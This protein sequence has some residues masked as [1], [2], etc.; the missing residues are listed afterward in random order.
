MREKREAPTITRKILPV[1]EALLGMYVTK[2]LSAALGRGVRTSIV[3]GVS[4][5]GFR[6]ATDLYPFRRWGPISNWQA[7]N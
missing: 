6:G 1:C 7:T 3:T 5:R 4:F 2:S